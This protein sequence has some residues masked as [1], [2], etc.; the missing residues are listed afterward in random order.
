[1]DE[2]KYNTLSLLKAKTGEL[3]W[4]DRNNEPQEVKWAGPPW[5]V[6]SMELLVAVHPEL[7][8]AVSAGHPDTR[9]AIS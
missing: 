1:M 8:A 2:N 5:V 7:V 6:P 3:F 4:R 9:T